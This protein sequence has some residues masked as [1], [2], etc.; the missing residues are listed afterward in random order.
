[1]NIECSCYHNFFLLTVTLL[2]A[3][4]ASAAEKDSFVG[5]NEV[6]SGR[7]MIFLNPRA[8]EHR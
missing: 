8:H 5:R 6:A 1:M 7:A 4:C 2:L 3:L